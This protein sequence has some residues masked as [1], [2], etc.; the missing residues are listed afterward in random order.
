MYLIAP[1][2]NLLGNFNIIDLVR[3]VAATAN[4]IFMWLSVQLSTDLFH[5]K[6]LK[7]S[8]INV[9]RNI[10]EI[11]IINTISKSNIQMLS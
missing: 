3:S 5:N 6:I 1:S 4:V 10:K 2:T 9:V 11:N 7:F 8:I